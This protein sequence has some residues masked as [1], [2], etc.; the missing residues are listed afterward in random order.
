MIEPI[1]EHIK[2]LDR[3]ILTGPTAS[4]VVVEKHQSIVQVTAS[5]EVPCRFPNEWA[6][7]VRAI[8]AVKERFG[9]KLVTK[10]GLAWYS[11]GKLQSLSLFIE[12]AA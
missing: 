3:G 7:A 10:C 4:Q 11:F 2:S 6:R 1:K 8:L 5:R 9:G 12:E